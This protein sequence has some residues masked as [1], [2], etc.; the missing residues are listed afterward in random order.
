MAVRRP[1]LAAMM[2]PLART[3]TNAEVPVLQAHEL[4]MWSYV[5]LLHLDD[6]P[7]RTQAAFAESIGADKTRI[8]EYLDELQDRGLIAREPDPSDR[9]ARLLRLT[10]QGRRV[11]DAAQRAIQRNEERLLSELPAAERDRFLR[12]LQRLAEAAPDVYGLD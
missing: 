9:R 11:R 2:L 10:P 5:V 6:E 4:T 12:S 1:D 7:V 8:I 3:L